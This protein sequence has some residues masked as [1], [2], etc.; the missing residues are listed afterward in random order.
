M[1][2]NEDDNV[3]DEILCDFRVMSYIFA[4]QLSAAPMVTESWRVVTG[5]HLMCLNGR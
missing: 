1:D 5:R 4:S 3:E 2:F